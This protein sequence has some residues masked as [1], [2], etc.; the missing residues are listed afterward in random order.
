MKRLAAKAGT[1][2][3]AALLLSLPASAHAQQRAIAGSGAS[4]PFVFS[5]LRFLTTP[6]S[7]FYVSATNTVADGNQLRIDLLCSQ[8]TDGSMHTKISGDAVVSWGVACTNPTLTPIGTARPTNTEMPSATA[9][10]ALS[11][12]P[13][14]G[15][16]ETPTPIA[17]GTTTLVP[18]PTHAVDDGEPDADT[19]TNI[20]GYALS[21]YFRESS[22]G[23]QI[24]VLSLPQSSGGSPGAKRRAQS[25]DAAHLSRWIPAFAVAPRAV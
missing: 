7:A 17:L 1:L 25:R 10:L 14:P 16:R 6:S 8:P 20:N 5:D 23:T 9:G 15:L 19:N 18:I 13:T 24:S 2:L 21:C 22:R 12:T 11:P 4:S 3:A